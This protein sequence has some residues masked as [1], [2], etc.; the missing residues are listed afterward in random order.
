MLKSRAMFEVKI[1]TYWADTD[2]AGIVFF[3]NFFRFAL[4]AEEEMYR[5]VGIEP[6]RFLDEHNVW[7]PRAEAFATFLAPIRHGEAIRVQ[8]IVEMKGEKSVRYNF[9]MFSDASGEKVAHGYIVA[10]CVD[11]ASF[12]PKAIPAG[13]REVLTGLQ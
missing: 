10:V 12:K 5:S 2:A 4:Q 3:P 13:M 7:F 8:M 11:R 6:Q 1:Q 9:E